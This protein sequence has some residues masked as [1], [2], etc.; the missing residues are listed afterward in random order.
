MRAGTSANVMA[1]PSSSSRVN[2][3]DTVGLVDDG[4]HSQL[5][6]VPQKSSAHGPQSSTFADKSRLS[7]ETPLRDLVTPKQ[8]KLTPKP[9]VI[10]YE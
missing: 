7:S 1:N 2:H 3:Y 8:I 6:S 9:E 10:E 4:E 5:S